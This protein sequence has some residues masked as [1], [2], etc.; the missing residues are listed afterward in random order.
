VDKDPGQESRSAMNKTLI[1]MFTAA[2]LVAAA[3]R[4]YS[5]GKMNTQSDEYTAWARGKVKIF[6][7]KTGKT[8][9]ADKIVRT[10]AEYAKQLDADTCYIVRE[11]GTEAPFTGKLL[12]E[13]R[14]GIFK[15]VVCGTDL[16]VSDT[17]FESGTGWPSFFQPVSTLNIV[18]QTDSS[19]GMIRTEARCARCGSHLGHVFSDGPKPTGLRYCMNSKALVFEEVK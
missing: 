11:G 16:F 13:H 3:G 17:K 14:K 18:E 9:E 8:T 5:M 10:E 6:D 12:D 4:I 1:V 15:C 7:Y 19:A 2:V